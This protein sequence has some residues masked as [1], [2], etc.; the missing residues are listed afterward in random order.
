[1]IIKTCCITGHRPE[2]LPWATLEDS[3]DCLRLK[4][5]LKTLMEHLITSQGITHFIN[6]MSRGWIPML[7]KSCWN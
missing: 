3:A 2:R 1:M 7:H 6:G 4:E 5:L